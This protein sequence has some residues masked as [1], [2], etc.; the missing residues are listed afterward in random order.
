MAFQTV[1]NVIANFTAL[2]PVVTPTV[3]LDSGNLFLFRARTEPIGETVN[4]GY[5][6]LIS[7]VILNSV[8]HEVRSTKWYPKDGYRLFSVPVP[9]TTPKSTFA[10]E[11]VV[12][13]VA[14][15]KGKV[16]PNT[17]AI[18]IEYDPALPQDLDFSST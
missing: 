16:D 14:L 12:K 3:T 4:Y 2:A 8:P 18:L 6:L 10:Y 13:P 15:Y 11:V 7:R 1:G 9:I 5:F 17:V